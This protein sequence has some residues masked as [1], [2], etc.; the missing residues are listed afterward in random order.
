MSPQALYHLD[1]TTR[2]KTLNLL[3]ICYWHE[4]LDMIL[5]FKITHEFV[6][7]VLA[8]FPVVRSSRPTRS[9]ADNHSK[10]VVP[11]HKTTTFQR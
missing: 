1:Y 10:F 9:L 5:F 11:R 8:L 2:L 6:A 4:F 7:I 3:Q